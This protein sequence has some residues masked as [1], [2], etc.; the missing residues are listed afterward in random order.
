MVSKEAIVRWITNIKLEQN[1]AFVYLATDMQD[2]L[3]L[4]WIKSKTGAV[5]RAE[6]YPDVNH[7]LKSADNN[8][9]SILEQEICADAKIFAGTQMSSWTMRVNEKRSRVQG[10]VFY[11]DMLSM[12][13][14]PDNSNATFYIDVETCKCEW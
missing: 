2:E 10:E 14:R 9:L 8:V 1:I 5:T 13:Q 12:G 6:I 11:A 7:E 4:K 3:L